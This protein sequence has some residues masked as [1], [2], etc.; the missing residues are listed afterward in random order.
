MS[1][2]EALAHGGIIPDVVQQFEPK[3]GARI[4]WNAKVFVNL[5]GGNKLTL[6][7]ST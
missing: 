7:Q 1:T 4:Q 5:E 3:V 2:A 6:E